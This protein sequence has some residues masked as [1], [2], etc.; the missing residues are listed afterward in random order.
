ML[1]RSV[2]RIDDQGRAKTL[3]GAYERPGRYVVTVTKEGY[4]TWRRERVEVR[5]GAC[6]VRTVELEAHLVPLSTAGG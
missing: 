6:H 4:V 1:I 2:A 5:R 3:A